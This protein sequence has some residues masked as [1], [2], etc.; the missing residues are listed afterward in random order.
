MF[1]SVI[2]RGCPPSRMAAF[3]A[4]RPKRV[5]AH[6]PQHVLPLPAPEVIEDVALRVVPDMANVKAARRIR[7]HLEQVV[8][9]L[10]RFAWRR[11]VRRERALV[12]PD[13]LPTLLDRLRVVCLL[14]RHFV[15]G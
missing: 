1:R 9:A 14:L 8:L 13:A 12:T 10:V 3:S 6:G 11:I 4:G 2:S 7:Q 15:S 5:P